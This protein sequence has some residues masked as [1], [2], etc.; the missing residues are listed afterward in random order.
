[1]S[2]PRER[3]HRTAGGAAGQ[4][5]RRRPIHRGV[6]RVVTLVLAVG[7]A[8]VG[9]A[10]RRQRPPQRPSPAPSPA[11]PGGG[12]AVTWT[13]VNSETDH[14]DRS[15]ASNRP[16]PSRSVRTLTARADADVHRD[17]HHQAGVAAHADAGRR[18]GP[19]AYTTT[20]SGSIPVASF[21]DSCNVTT[22]TA[23]DRPR[24]RRLRSGQRP[25]RPGAHR[26]LDLDDQP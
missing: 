3:R 12:W 22:V 6:S 11:S 16:P 14:R 1:M 7:F 25:L 17:R 15:P 21:S 2:S 5:D 10:G 20:S 24:R 18:S 8:V 9:I 26:A 19:T 23:P 13:V 4:G